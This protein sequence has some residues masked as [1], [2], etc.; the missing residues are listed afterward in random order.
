MKFQE[1]G[2]P[3]PQAKIEMK[4]QFSQGKFSQ[5]IQRANRLDAV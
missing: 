3:N 5:L 1:Q 2:V 4:V